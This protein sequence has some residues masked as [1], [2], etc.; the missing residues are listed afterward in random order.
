MTM[1]RTLVVAGTG[2]CR[3][4]RPQHVSNKNQYNIVGRSHGKFRSFHNDIALSK[5]SEY[6]NHPVRMSRILRFC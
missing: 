5:L 2:L 4:L 3:G 6:I 1:V